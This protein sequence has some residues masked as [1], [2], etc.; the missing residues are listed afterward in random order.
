MLA[1]SLIVTPADDEQASYLRY[2]HD[3]MT[4]GNHT[5]KTWVRSGRPRVRGMVS[6]LMALGDGT[7]KE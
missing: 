4:Y 3:E 2:V 7:L 5:A 1:L 6:E